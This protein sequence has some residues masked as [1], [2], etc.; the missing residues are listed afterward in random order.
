MAEARIPV[1][2]FNPG[3][4]F[5]CL[6]FLEA[7]EVL[8]GSAEGGFD[9]SNPAEVVFVLRANGERNPVEV[10]LQF[11]AEAEV[12]W[13]SPSEAYPERDGGPTEFRPGIHPSV[14]VKPADL[15]GALSGGFSGE[16]FAI[17]IGFWA[18]GS[19]PFSQ[20]F[21]K[22]S[23]GASH[24]V[25]VK[26]CLEFVR[27]FIGLRPADFMK[28]NPDFLFFPR[29]ADILFKIDP[30]AYQ[31]SIES[32]FAPDQLRKAGIKLNFTSSPVCELLAVVG[33]Q[34]H[35]PKALSQECFQYEVWGNP[36]SEAN[37]FAPPILSRASLKSLFPPICIREFQV[38]H[39]LASETQAAGDRAITGVKEV[40]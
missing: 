38:R 11:L 36:G 18:D 28:K 17:Q 25:R 32:G 13:F 15:P 3:Q 31:K 20:T 30:L 5:A 29:T 27:E 40:T 16:K 10:V 1:D 2:L 35:R 37:Y 19:G 26:K 34:Y 23:N 24:H 4:V 33:L 6:G 22:S 21:K 12:I 7:A 14:Q 39:V 8:C 9:W